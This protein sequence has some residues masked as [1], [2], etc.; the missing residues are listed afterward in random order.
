MGIAHELRPHG[1][2]AA[3][4]DGHARAGIALMIAVLFVWCAAALAIG[5]G[6]RGIDPDSATYLDAARSL[7]DGD[8]YL[9]RWAYWDPIYT[10]GRLPTATSLWP[11][12]FSLVVAAGIAAGLDAVTSARFVVFTSF[13]LVLVMM[14]MWTRMLTSHVAAAICAAVSMTPARDSTLVAT[15]IPFLCAATASLLC[16]ARALRARGDVSHTGWWIAASLAAGT[17]FLMRYVGLACV[18]SVGTVAVAAWLARR[19]SLRV[20]VVALLPAAAI[21]AMTFA[22]NK[23]VSGHFGQPWPGD[24]IFWSSL[25][26]AV[27]STAAAFL[28]SDVLNGP[29]AA[30]VAAK[31]VAL[32]LLVAIAARTLSTAIRE[33]PASARLDRFGSTIVIVVFGLF[34]TGLTVAATAMNGMNIEPRYLTVIA[35]WALALV[36]GW[37]CVSTRSGTRDGSSLARWLCAVWVL[38]EAAAV[39]SAVRAAPYNYVDAGAS[40]HGIAWVRTNIAPEEVLL[41]NR[42]ADL[43]F[44]TANPVARLPRLPHSA[45]GIRSVAEL[46]DLADRMGARYLVHFRGYPAEAKYNRAEFDFVRQFDNPARFGTR[47]VAQFADAIIYRI[48]GEEH[49]PRAVRPVT[50]P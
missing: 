50:A 36:A 24:D 27:K 15:E 18:A 23:L 11:P 22:R 17:A 28:H 35:P 20:C 34:T 7:A 29:L 8:G 10:T 47:V 14:F 4:N 41:T 3:E 12:G 2:V 31:V 45:Q 46:D 44:W 16:C 37:A 21:V 48:G 9:H 26:G 30:L 5:A 1:A 25:P 6:T 19:I 49:R 43:A 33:T 38:T 13:A 39:L 42:G 40:S 32:L